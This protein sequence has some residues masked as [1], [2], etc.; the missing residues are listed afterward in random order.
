MEQICQMIDRD[1]IT[2]RVM[3]TRCSLCNTV[4]RSATREEIDDADYAPQDQRRAYFL[5]VRPLSQTLLEWIAR[6]TYF[7]EDRGAKVILGD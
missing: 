6:K 4:L 2:R 5:L 7:T 1:L 3:M